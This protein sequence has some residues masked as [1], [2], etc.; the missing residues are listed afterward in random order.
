LVIFI[1][2]LKFFRIFNAFMVQIMFFVCFNSNNDCFIHFV[3]ND[4]TDLN[5]AGIAFAHVLPP[6]Y[7]RDHTWLQ[8]YLLAADTEFSFTQ[9]GFST[10]YFLTHVTNPSR[11]I[12][13]ASSQLETKVE[14]L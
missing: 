2:R 8:G 6:S 11:V 7:S 5:F 1:V 10:S 4:F 14:K 3:T 9:N 13:L 12:Q